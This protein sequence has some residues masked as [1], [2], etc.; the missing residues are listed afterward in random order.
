M[1]FENKTTEELIK[2]A[3]AGLGFTLEAKNKSAEEIRSIANVALKSGARITLVD[4][5][6]P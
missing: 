1:S 4:K 3:E 2:V 5:N 6:F